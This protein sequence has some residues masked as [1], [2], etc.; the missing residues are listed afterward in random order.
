MA[1]LTA[2]QVVNAFVAN[3]LAALVL[4]RMHDIEAARLLHD[5]AGAGLRRFSNTMSDPN[6]W[7]FAVF[8][9]HDKM[10]KA[11]L[12]PEADRL[13][14][15]A[16]WVTEYGARKVLKIL[17]TPP[18]QVNWEQAYYTL[19]L[20]RDRFSVNSTYL[21]RIA[22]TIRTWP[23]R[24]RVEQILA[25]S[26][27]FHYLLQSDPKSRLLPRVRELAQAEAIGAAQLGTR[28]RGFFRMDED[29][30][31]VAG[32]GGTSAA[33]VGSFSTGIG[34]TAPNSIIDPPN[35][36]STPAPALATTTTG[37]KDMGDIL[38]A[39]YKHKLGRKVRQKPAQLSK[40][41]AIKKKDGKIIKRKRRNWLPRTFKDPEL[42]KVLGDYSDVK[43][44]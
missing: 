8:F 20:I 37:G 7:G 9:P 1:N 44:A 43:V 22:P 33:N 42:N 27:A 30:A 26:N 16:K 13:H 15:M 11:R 4:M 32:G 19:G 23:S 14:D 17:Q 25:L 34:Q 10:V 28:M 39:L 38:R 2:D 6:F 18:D 40:L 5:P 3:Y 12:G 35:W 21:L 31:S 41:K 24:S 36:N 29:G